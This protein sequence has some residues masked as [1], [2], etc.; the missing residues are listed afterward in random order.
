MGDGHCRWEPYEYK[1]TVT[2]TKMIAFATQLPHFLSN[3]SYLPITQIDAQHGFASANK[4]F[5][6]CH[7]QKVF[8]DLNIFC[9]LSSFV[10][11][12]PT[13]IRELG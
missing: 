7:Q 13:T 2:L 5:V 10:T 11:P 9:K 3:L 4:E 6:L 8:F 1:V 12:S